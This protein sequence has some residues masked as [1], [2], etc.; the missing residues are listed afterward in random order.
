MQAAHDPHSEKRLLPSVASANRHQ[1][2]HFLF[3]KPDF[4]AAELRKRQV[5]YFERLTSCLSRFVKSV[6]TFD[7]SGHL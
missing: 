1:T 6:G 5:F 7:R 2:W 3:G 4:L